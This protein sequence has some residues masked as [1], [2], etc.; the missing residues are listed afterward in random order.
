MCVLGEHEQ[1]RAARLP[2]RRKLVNDKTRYSN[3]LT[4]CLKMYF[5]Q[6]MEWFIE[7]SSQ[8]TGD[9]LERWPA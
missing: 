7:L 9:F 6:V 8:V 2:G 3:R 4:A 1:Q 5:P